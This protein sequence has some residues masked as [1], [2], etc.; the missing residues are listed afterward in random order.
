MRSRTHLI[1]L[2]ICLAALMIFCL[3][4]PGCSAPQ[5]QSLII[6]MA[7]SV[8]RTSQTKPKTQILDDALLFSTGM[9]VSSDLYRFPI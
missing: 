5:E 2:N 7:Y 6:E 3:S 9:E 8:R 1:S 4:L